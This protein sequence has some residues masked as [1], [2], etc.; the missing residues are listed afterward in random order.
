MT[1]RP[2]ATRPTEHLALV[3]IVVDDYDTALDFYV[4]KMGFRLVEDTPVSAGKRWV[5][6]APD[7]QPETSGCHLLLAQASEPAQVA[8]IG[9]QT[10]GR[11]AFFLH[12][13]DF[14]ASHHRL[15]TNGV[16]FTDGPRR[17]PYGTVAVFLD[18][19]GNRWDLI[20]PTCGTQPG[21]DRGPE[22][23]RSIE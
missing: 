4:A 23:S 18:R 20:E 8:S 6:V 3:T 22:T 10:G 12:T 13:S 1:Q 11:V 14:A 9:S 19:Y 17:E 21:G 2:H 16:L 7:G 15:T 5:V